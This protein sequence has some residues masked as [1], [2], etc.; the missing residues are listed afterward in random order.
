MFVA[1]LMDSKCVCWLCRQ[2]LLHDVLGWHIYETQI[3][4]AYDME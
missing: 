1:N 4:A 3:E 2:V